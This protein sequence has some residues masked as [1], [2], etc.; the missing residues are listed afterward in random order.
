MPSPLP[1]RV[2]AIDLG[3]NA[4]RFVA[5]ERVGRAGLAELAFDRAP[6]RMGHDAF[7]TGRLTEGAMD[8]AVA[9]LSG[10]R[11]RMDALGVTRYRAVATSAVRESGNGGAFVERVRRECG[12]RLETITGE[13]EARLVWLAARRRVELGGRGW[14][15]VDVGGGSAE[16]ARVEADRILWTES[17]PL[18]A[19]R[20]LEA[21]GAGGP[22]RETSRVLE[23][24]VEALRGR[25]DLRA[26]GMIGIGGNIETLAALSRAV[27]DPRGASALPVATLRRLIEELTPLSPRERIER[28]GV[29]EDRADVLVPA[30]M[31]Y[32]GLAEAVGAEQIVVPWTGVKEGILLELLGAGERSP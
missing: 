26:A 2:A 6:V 7:R 21:G 8:A 12:I 31:V 19:V 1:L 11:R 20:L 32:A 28:Y 5:A 13:E 10:F 9:A 27:A 16:V 18:G 4:L 15:L 3:S 24:E 23:E 25:R 29:R 30:A 22:V 14:I 17:R